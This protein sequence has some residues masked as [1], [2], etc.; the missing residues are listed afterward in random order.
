MKPGV[1]VGVEVVVVDGVVVGFGVFFGFLVW[2][3]M[4]LEPS[5]VLGGCVDDSVGHY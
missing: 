2:V 4:H 1:V 3:V 5:G